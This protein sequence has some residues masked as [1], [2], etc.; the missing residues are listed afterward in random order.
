[1]VYIYPASV[2]PYTVNCAME[3]VSI[4][5]VIG[6]V[7]LCGVSDVHADT[8]LTAVTGQPKLLDGEINA[9]EQ[10]AVNL[11]TKMK[12]KFSTLESSL[13][14]S[15]TN[16]F[17]PAFMKG[18]VK[19]AITGIL[20]EGYIEDII[21][22]SV[23][24]EV[25]NLKAT[26]RNTKT[27]LQAE[28]QQFRHVERERDTFKDSFVKLRGEQTKNVHS[29]QLQLNETVAGLRVAKRVNT[30]LR[31]DLMT[32]NTSCVKMSQVTKR[33][34]NEKQSCREGLRGMQKKFSTDIQSLNNHLNRTIDDLHDSEQRIT[35]L[36]ED[37]MALKT[38]FVMREGIKKNDVNETLL[39]TSPP[40]FPGAAGALRDLS[41]TARTSVTTRRMPATRATLSPADCA[42]LFGASEHG[43]LEEVKWLL[44]LN[45]DINCRYL[46]GLTPVMWAAGVGHKYMV[47]FLLCKGADASLVDDEDRNILHYVGLGGV[48]ETARFVLSL[49]VVDI[50]ARDSTGMS[51]LDLARLRKHRRVADLLVSQGAQ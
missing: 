51:A 35:G 10:T 32:L 45:I 25:N 14:E 48:F 12:Y 27:Q 36:T 39:S 47:E 4:A 1:M 29:L 11:E 3:T 31:Q 15:L 6:L 2:Q 44:S 43:N 33:L 24:D 37:I 23:L 17:I 16:T 46:W 13:T 49:N 20:K 19:Q 8:S 40:L 7:S 41:R 21:S 42:D 26:V 34:I 38:S 30:V 18:L 28:T 9:W 50:N 5:I 22:G